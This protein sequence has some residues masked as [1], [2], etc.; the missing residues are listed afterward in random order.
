M[1]SLDPGEQFEQEAVRLRR[2]IEDA[3]DPRNM[4]RRTSERYA[5]PTI[6]MVAPYDG[7]GD[8]DESTFRQVRCRDISRGGFSFFWPTLLNS[9]HVIVRFSDG[10]GY[11]CLKARVVRCSRTA[12]LIDGC[13]V[14]CQFLERV[15]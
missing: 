6:Q 13:L 2:A 1:S 12:N 11:V 3:L 7:L 15:Q 5:F 8:P 14:R 4:E 9:E 10:R